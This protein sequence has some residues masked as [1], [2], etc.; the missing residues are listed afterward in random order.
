MRSSRRSF[1]ALPSGKAWLRAVAYLA[2]ALLHLPLVFIALYAFN[3]D[4]GGYNFPMSG[5]T[6]RWVSK[7]MERTDIRDAIVLSLSV[8]TV[9][10]LIAM[11]LGTLTE[12]GRASC[13]ERV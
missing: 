8:A 1:F 6:L 3:D 9:A 10:T 11:V 7:A 13:R 5:L 2:L 12:I 4:S